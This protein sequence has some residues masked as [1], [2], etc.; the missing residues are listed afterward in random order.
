[1]T[2]KARQSLTSLALAL[3]FLS[4]YLS[5]GLSAPVPDDSAPKGDESN[6]TTTNSTSSDTNTTT[7]NSTDG[8]STS[9]A[10]A[11]LREQLKLM[12]TPILEKK[13][14]VNG[15]FIFAEGF[16]LT[17]IGSDDPAQSNK[18]VSMTADRTMN[19]EYKFTTNGWVDT[20][21]DFLVEAGDRDEE[22]DEDIKT[23]DRYFDVMTE[24]AALQTK[25]DN[26]YKKSIGEENESLKDGREGASGEDSDNAQSEMEVKESW[27]MQ[28]M[29]ETNGKGNADFSRKDYDKYSDLTNEMEMIRPEF[30]EL[31]QAIKAA[32]QGYMIKQKIRASPAIFN[33]SMVVGGALESPN[34]KFAATFIPSVVNTTVLPEDVTKDLSENLEDG[35]KNSTVTEGQ[36]A[37]SINDEAPEPTST[38]SKGGSTETAAS[39]TSSGE[40]AA[41]TTESSTSS[42]DGK[43]SSTDSS[44][45]AK[46]T[47]S[48]NSERRR[49]VSVPLRRHSHSTHPPKRGLLANVVKDTAQ[50]SGKRSILAN[51]VKDTVEGTSKRSVLADVVKDT[52]QSTSK[53]G[54]L[55]SVVKDAAQTAAKRY[56]QSRSILKDVVADTVHNRAAATGHRNRSLKL[57]RGDNETSSDN[58]TSPDSS[59]TNS[60]STEDTQ[61]DMVGDQKIGVLILLSLQEGA[62]V[63]DRADFINYAYAMNE[64]LVEKYFGNADSHG[65]LRYRCTHLV[66]GTAVPKDDMDGELGAVKL[67]GS[68]WEELVVVKQLPW[69]KK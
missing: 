28:M 15:R 6:T 27:A 23:S 55:G 10:S 33:F 51:A 63:N 29:K 34:A 40:S 25:L 45:S 32:S 5:P 36:I 49:R 52:A 64:T 37:H 42:S 58:S 11:S 69:Y 9:N 43:P 12:V 44:S 67:I 17:A 57:G 18:D 61:F 62:W 59:D 56:A 1:M 19:A 22:A 3:L 65:P 30:E 41:S 14:G 2:S 21:A 24:L 54:F 8:N 16:A 39:T 48:G 26:A 66:L 50:S 20:Y 53:R 60:T 68:V 4:C 47:E 35:V 46:P 7:S 31:D 13:K 38:S